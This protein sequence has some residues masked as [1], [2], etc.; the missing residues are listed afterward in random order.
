M[1]YIIP[2]PRF[3]APELLEPGRKPT[4]NVVID[5]NHPLT[6]GLIHLPF[7]NGSI[8]VDLVTGIPFENIDGTFE[9]R[10]GAIVGDGSTDII[11]TPI[12][13]IALTEFSM[14]MVGSFDNIAENDKRIMSLGSS[15]SNNPILSIGNYTAGSD[16]NFFY[17]N[18][19]TENIIAQ[20]GTLTNKEVR[21]M[22]GTGN[23]SNVIAQSSAK[24]YLDGNLVDAY[25]STEFTG[26]T[27]VDRLAIFGL[28]RAASATQAEGSFKIG[29]VYDKE[30]S[31]EII[32]L[33][34]INPYQFMIPA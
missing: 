9:T 23:T 7:F 5:W 15:S 6:K 27:T 10:S 17:R 13:Q 32:N 18:D 31:D 12:K 25:T 4:G 8:I 26:A 22:V 2:D 21:V 29:M 14:L 3:E 16:I 11:W 34:S 24:I 30:L 19:S 20:G 28:Q 1:S 33:L